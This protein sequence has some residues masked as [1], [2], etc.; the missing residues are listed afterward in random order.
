ML[1]SGD[2]LT[3]S[4]FSLDSYAYFFERGFEYS[5]DLDILYHQL[6][7]QVDHWKALHRERFVELSYDVDEGRVSIVDS[8][9]RDECRYRLSA[10]ASA[11]YLACDF[12][13]I[14]LR[15]IQSQLE[16]A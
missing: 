12:R 6:C 7:Q 4:G 11:V 16:S 14:S 8:R 15:L 3:R 2:F 13:P 1:F 5:N 10:E 9:Y